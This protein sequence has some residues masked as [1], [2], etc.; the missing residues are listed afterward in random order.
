MTWVAAPPSLFLLIPA[1]L[2]LQVCCRN[3]AAGAL[4]Q[5]LCCRGYA[6][7]AMLQGLCCGKGG[8]RTRWPSSKL[9]PSRSSTQQISPK[10]IANHCN[11]LDLHAAVFYDF[12]HAD[13]QLI[14]SLQ[15]TANQ[16]LST[17]KKHC[18]TRANQRKSLQITPSENH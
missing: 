4:L 10:S 1:L 3:Y 13:L 18:K 17:F 14:C 12:R 15:I 11:S 16:S 5:G 7:G 2:L 6:A 8:R 9:I